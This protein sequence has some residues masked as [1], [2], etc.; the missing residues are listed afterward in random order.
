MGAVSYTHLDVYKRQVGVWHGTGLNFLVFGALQGVGLVTVHYYTVWLKQKLGR[1]KFAAYRNN[2]GIRV[3]ATMMTFAYFSATL[4]FFANTW[5]QML[6]IKDALDVYKRQVTHNRTSRLNLKEEVV[7]FL[8]LWAL[9]LSC[10]LLYT[11][12]CV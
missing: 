5:E 4:F 10:C 9:R 8:P 2:Q 11:S 7:F 6:A 1:D 12:R 3:V